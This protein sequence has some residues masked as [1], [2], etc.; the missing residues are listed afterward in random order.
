MKDEVGGEGG[1]ILECTGQYH[2]YGF[3]LFLCIL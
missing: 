3:I 2:A 1:C